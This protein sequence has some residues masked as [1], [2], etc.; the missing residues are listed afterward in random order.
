MR[1]SA[2]YSDVIL[3]ISDLLHS[4]RQTWNSFADKYAIA[5]NIAF[6]GDIAC[7]DGMSAL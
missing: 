4:Q 3:K 1:K 5:D 2:L 7:F 6:D